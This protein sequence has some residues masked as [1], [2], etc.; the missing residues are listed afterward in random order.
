MMQAMGKSN[1]AANR[2]RC[3]TGSDAMRAA[4][5]AALAPR[6]PTP[7][8]SEKRAARYAPL[9]LRICRPAVPVMI[10]ARNCSSAQP[11]G[12]PAF[13][14]AVGQSR[15]MADEAMSGAGRSGATPIG[16]N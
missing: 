2:P 8:I 10:W 13:C 14:T 1:D 16:N 4:S 7:N 15:T 5:A 3:T 11:G 9:S 6:W 12:L